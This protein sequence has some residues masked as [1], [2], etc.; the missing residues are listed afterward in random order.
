MRACGRAAHCTAWQ[1]GAA[2]A[3]PP[4]WLAAWA[5]RVQSS[6]GHSA[7]R[8]VVASC[9]PCSILAERRWPFAALNT[10][11]PHPLDTQSHSPACLRLPL[12]C[13]ASRDVDAEEA[14]E[15]PWAQ[16]EAYE[17]EQMKKAAAAF[18]SKDKRPKAGGSAAAV[19]C[20]GGRTSIRGD[21]SGK[22]GLPVSG[23]GGGAL[24]P[25]EQRC[26]GSACV[27]ANIAMLP[28][29]CPNV[30]RFLRLCL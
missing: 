22:R 19:G 21:G 20:H 10:M 23:A 27:P 17:A 9:P 16:Q 6:T 14:A 1:H 18:G 24:P 7:G 29:H 15:T 26:S 4:S 5:A 3:Q 8:A 30:S 28:C 2:A 11:C 25:R 12:P 13:L